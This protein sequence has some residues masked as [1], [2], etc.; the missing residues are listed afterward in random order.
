M[1]M[2][3]L[4]AASGSVTFL[5]GW[6][7]TGNFTFVDLVAASTNALN[8]AL[9][10]R[11]PDHYKNFTLV[12]ILLMAMLGGLAGGISRD[13]MLSDVPAALTNP[14]YITP[15]SPS[16]CSATRSPM[17]RGSCFARASSSS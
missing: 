11:R 15:R 16:G 7:L 6:D 12:G 9:L 3:L 1:T 4:L 13:I 14:A 8:G 10:A 5:E 17:R 2:S